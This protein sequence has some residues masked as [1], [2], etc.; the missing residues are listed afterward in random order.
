VISICADQ[1]HQPGDLQ[2]RQLGDRQ[3]AGLLRDAHGRHLH[4]AG[5]E[6][7]VGLV[8]AIGGD[9]QAHIGASCHRR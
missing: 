1:L 9:Q 3:L 4:H 2:G 6:R 7:P 8:Q 5:D